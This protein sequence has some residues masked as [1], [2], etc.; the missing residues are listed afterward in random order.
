[1]YVTIIHVSV[2]DMSLLLC[3]CP[4]RPTLFLSAPR[5]TLLSNDTYIV[6][7]GR[8]FELLCLSNSDDTGV[9]V[10]QVDMPDRR[11][12]SLSPTVVLFA[13]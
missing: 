5:Q 10:T 8:F 4:D 3:A 9:L 11:T 7:E 13:F 12:S 1:M 6:E 2:F